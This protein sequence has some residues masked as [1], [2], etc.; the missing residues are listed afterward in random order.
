MTAVKDV[1]K[2]EST[3]V[4]CVAIGMGNRMST[5]LQEPP[6]LLELNAIP[7]LEL[8][9]NSMV[10]QQNS[11]VSSVFRCGQHPMNKLACLF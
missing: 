10:N 1:Y 4:R 3:N 8:P 7:T 5:P 2:I 6:R 11:H 9:G